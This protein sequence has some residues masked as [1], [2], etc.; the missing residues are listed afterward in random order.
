MSTVHE[1]AVAATLYELQLL[2][3]IQSA[4][5]QLSDIKPSEWVESNVVMGQPRPGPYR[6]NYTPYCR[7]IINRLHGSDPARWIAVMKGL[8]IGISAGVIIP[9]MGWIIKESPANT[10]F[11]VGAPD[12]VDK[13][14]EKLDL[15]IDN[16]GLRN[17]I[18]PQVKRNRM[19]K[20]GDTNTKKDFSGGFIN[21]TTPNNHKEWRDVSL[22]YGFIDDF[23]AAK[24]A[25]KES[26]STRK[27]IEGRFAAYKDTHKIFYIS[28]PERK[29]TSNIEPAYLLGDQRKYLIP[30]PCC[31]AFIELRWNIP[32]GIG[33]IWQDAMPEGAGVVWKLDGKNQLI[34]SS[35]GYVCQECGG[36]FKDNDKQRL[37]NEGYWQ[38]TAEPKRR[39]FYSYHISSLYAPAGMYD[40][41]HYVLNYLE[42]CPPGQPRNE[43]EYM[44]FLN[45]CLGVTYEGEAEQPK[46]T[47]ISGNTRRYRIGSIPEKQSIADGN[48][49]IVLVTMGSD[50]NGTEDDARLDWEVV[51]W[52]ETGASYSVAHGS[53]GTF[54]PR[55]NTRVE[56]TDREKWTYQ[57]GKPN[58]VWSE[59]DKIMRH[60]WPS[61]T[62]PTTY[63]KINM[64]AIDCGHL[65]ELI[66]P[67][68]DWTIGRYP[69]N[70]CVGVRGNKEE[71]Y[72]IEGTNVKLYEVGK[73][74]NDVYYLQVGHF[75]DML[76]NYMK[77][78]W[79]EGEGPQPPNFMNFPRPD[80]GLY[81]FD[82]Y[83]SHYEAEER[84]IVEDAK[85]GRLFRWVKRNSAVQNH[86]FDC[87]IYAMAMKE[88]IVAELGKKVKPKDQEGFTWADF[89][90][91]VT[92]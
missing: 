80:E 29:S 38:P 7:E 92:T 88:I 8:Q 4:N 31:G 32:E 35:V 76:S 19:N 86:L 55:E 9:G 45:T 60:A 16:A 14:V 10:Y 51:A 40:W 15:M 39:G 11:T 82:N 87:R 72:K 79:K 48:G 83:F 50:M 65:S 53:I 59:L 85:G 13:S 58:S 33:T 54:I 67:Y 89:V 2:D 69:E 25:S 68:I 36:F 66:W 75:K 62:T 34:E 17:Y 90:T 47:Q 56:K 71:K 52:A 49:R 42:A 57:H 27:L 70:P 6:Y 41:K 61:D 12:L 30:C 63:Y 5:V 74:R 91:Y 23:E 1:N 28:T 26:G 44:T 20:S 77:L 84:K 81:E 24:T 73:S 64:P 18:K 37:L 46:A 21:I 43:M 3:I 78:Q 22:K